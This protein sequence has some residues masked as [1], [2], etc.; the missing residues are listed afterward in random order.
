[1]GR[2]A[3]WVAVGLAVLLV[4]IA[5]AGAGVVSSV[6]GGG[7]NARCLGASTAPGVS[8]AQRARS[9]VVG[10]PT[11]VPARG[12]ERLSLTDAAR[13]VQR[14]AFSSGHE[15]HGARETEDVYTGG[16]VPGCDGAAVSAS[17]WTRPVAGTVSSG[18]R[19]TDRPEHDGVDIMAPRGTVIRAASDGVVVRVRCNI[20]GH[21]W[22]PNGGPMPC[23][24][25][26][27]PTAGGCG[28]YAEI[29]H[30]GDITSRYCHMVRQPA[31]SV[32]QPVVAGHPIGHVGTSGNSSGPHLH[33]EIHEGYPATES[34]AVN[35]IPFMQ[36]NDV[37]L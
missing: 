33:Y 22:E 36:S 11:R 21:S 20:G 8:P 37:P 12:W 7:A 10:E 24:T 27:S 5:G 26:G 13:A 16:T 6:L 15:K 3:L 28:W 25:D 9:A 23:D 34:N 31:V 18:Y 4:A 14:S 29:R 1:V 30:A 32:G 17:G 19:T 35:P 2:V